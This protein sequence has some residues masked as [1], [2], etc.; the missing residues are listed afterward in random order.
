MSD[1]DSHSSWKVRYY[2]PGSPT[3]TFI[4][5]KSLAHQWAFYLLL[6][7]MTQKVVHQKVLTL[8]VTL[9]LWKSLLE[10]ELK[11]FGKCNNHDVV[12]WKNEWIFKLSLILR[13]I[14]L[15]LPLCVIILIIGYPINIFVN[16][17]FTTTKL[18]F[19]LQNSWKLP[20]KI[21]NQVTN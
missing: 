11:K 7:F 19:T 14:Y 3:S 9:S 15:D 16:D 12:K 4:T 8:S 21:I 10:I 1:A 20:R 6:P 2:G 18:R 13:I 17:I 5:W